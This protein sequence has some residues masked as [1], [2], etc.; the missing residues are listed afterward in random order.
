MIP[1]AIQILSHASPYAKIS[2]DFSQKVEK[3]G[4]GYL[5]AWCPQQ[6]IL[7]HPVSEIRFIYDFVCNS[8]TRCLGHWM[9]LISLWT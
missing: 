7:N 2:N 1:L 8:S 9:V 6:R 3:S 4:I 5:S